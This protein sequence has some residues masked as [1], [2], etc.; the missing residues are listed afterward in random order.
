MGT[1]N[2]KV[3]YNGDI[4]M[5]EVFF[6][7]K[8]GYYDF[9]DDDRIQVRY[10]QEGNVIGFMIEGVKGIRGWIDAELRDKT[11]KTA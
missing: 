5:L 11:Q 3:S 2:I 8:G 10:D 1:K 6:E 7:P 9:T 4:D